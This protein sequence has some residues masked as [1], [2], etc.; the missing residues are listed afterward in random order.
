VAGAAG[1]PEQD[2][3]LVLLADL[4]RVGLE[5]AEELARKTYE[6][7]S[8]AG[9]PDAG[10]FLVGQLF[11]IR[12]HQGRLAEMLDDVSGAA[13]EFPGVVAFRTA[14]AMILADQG[15]HTDATAILDAI[16]GPGGSGVP[17]DLDWLA[18][19][20]FACHAAVA[21]GDTVKT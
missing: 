4:V 13:E 6:Y 8:A 1:H 7:C 19:M 15:R 9:E 18:T 16:F 14:L 2:A 12:V 10:A 11:N 5:R 17:D 20:A 3:A 21:C